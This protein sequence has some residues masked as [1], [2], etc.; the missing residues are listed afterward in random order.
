MATDGIEFPLN[1][2]MTT[3]CTNDRYT[4]PE[5]LEYNLI[6]PKE[7]NK[8]ASDEVQCSSRQCRT[9]EI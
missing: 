4:Y 7:F 8:K 6:K 3:L 1:K 9:V 2:T 5:I